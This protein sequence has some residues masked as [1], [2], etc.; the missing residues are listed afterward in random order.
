MVQIVL[1]EL[2]VERDDKLVA[3]NS[4]DVNDLKKQIREV[5]NVLNVHGLIH[6]K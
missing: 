6:I 4:Q 2:M 5:M 1:K 3:L